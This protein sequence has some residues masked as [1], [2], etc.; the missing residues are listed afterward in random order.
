MPAGAG[1]L[2]AAWAG[3]AE[4]HRAAAVAAAVAAA[5]AVPHRV[6]RKSGFRSIDGSYLAVSSPRRLID[7]RVARTVFVHQ[8]LTDSLLT[9]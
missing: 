3:A 5:T 6:V 9:I 1:A 7:I 4:T 8:L 2:A